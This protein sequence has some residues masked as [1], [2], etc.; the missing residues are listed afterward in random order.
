[1]F[2]ENVKFNKEYARKKFLVIGVVVVGFVV[3]W[4]IL[5]TGKIF[6]NKEMSHY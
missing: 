3:K 5:L 6:S 1:M 4:Q 2:M